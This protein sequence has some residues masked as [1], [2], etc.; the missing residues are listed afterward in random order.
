MLGA[1]LLSFDFRYWALVRWLGGE[2]CNSHQDWGH[3][4]RRVFESVQVPVRHGY[5][6]LFPELAM[7]SLREG[8]PL[9]GS[10]VSKR[11]DFLRRFLYDNHP[12]LRGVL[13]D[14]REKFAKEEALSFHLVFPKFVALFI[15]GMMISPI[16]WLFRKGK[17][18]LIID[19][20]SPLGPDDT[21]APNSHIPPTGESDKELENPPVFYG[22]ALKRHLTAIWNMRISYPSDELL[23]HTDDIDAAFRRILYHPVLA[24]VFSYVF[25]EF[26][27]VPVGN[28]FGSRSAP[29]WF[30]IIAELRAHMANVLNYSDKLS[31]PLVRDLQFPPESRGSGEVHQPVHA[32]ADAFHSG[33]VSL[34]P[35]A[36]SLAHH[37][38]M[39][40]DDNVLVALRR[41]ASLAV[42]AA[43]GSAYDCFGSPDFNARRGSVLSKAKFDPR[44]SA[45][46]LFVGLL[47]DTHSMTVTWP[48]EKRAAARALLDE[49]LSNRTSRSPREAAQLLGIIRHGAFLSVAGNYLSIRLQWVLSHHTSFADLPSRGRLRARRWWSSYKLHIPDSVYNDLRLLRRS[50]EE[51]SAASIWSRP[52]GLLIDRSPTCVVFSD[53]SYGGI[54][55]WSGSLQFLWRVTR[56]ELIQCGFSMREIDATG[57]ALRSD[58][59]QSSDN[60]LHINLLEFV[61]IL[62]NLW[63]TLR[64]IRSEEAPLGGHIVAV[65]A[66]NTSALSWLRH[67]SRSNSRPIQNLAHFCQCLILTSQTAQCA[68]VI[69][70]HVPGVNNSE[71]DALSRP[72]TYATLGSAIEA[73]SQLQT[74]HVFQIPFSVLSL[75]AKVVSSDKIGA[76]LDNETTALFH[77]E[78]RSFR[79]GSI[80]TD[81]SF[82]GFFRRSRRGKA[83][84]S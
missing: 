67:A 38:A 20:S 18:R 52:I 15:P 71:A 28:I 59:G 74:C 13:P 41:C 45:C 39:F 65:L 37:H 40:V 14:V 34:L 21:G 6:T 61:A 63:L 48:E 68:N 4:H 58:A 44:L 83:S 26:S 30:T 75:I 78:P 76:G 73:F 19:A 56:S 84:R 55:G 2:Y 35:S 22:T 62:V 77:Q 80:A 69:G 17:G 31:D 43:L 51:P 25:Q 23:Q 57:E 29:S 36:S 72:E 49:W 81:S 32:V 54:G 27:I 53:A 47:I 9:S 46:V 1:A 79:P 50:L 82:R 12:P 5:P 3:T 16:S 7:R 60:A 64:W 42:A 8:V 11:S 33:V 70:K 10:F 24:P 66:D